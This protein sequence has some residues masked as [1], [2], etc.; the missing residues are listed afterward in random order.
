M[1]LIEVS[2]VRVMPS[3]D[4]RSPAWALDRPVTG[5]LFEG[6]LLEVSGWIVHPDVRSVEICQGDERLARTRVDAPRADVARLFPAIPAAGLSGFS[7][8]VPLAAWHDTTFVVSAV[9]RDA[10]PI[11]IA[12]IV[13]GRRWREACDESA[14]PL[15]S[16]VVTHYNGPGEL[17]ATIESVVA[18]TH[19]HSEILLV[20]QVALQEDDPL[21]RRY[22]HIRIVAADAPGQAAAR[23][24]GIRHSIGDFLMF[25]DRGDRLAPDALAIACAAFRDHPESA[26]VLG[27]RAGG[28]GIHS[29]TSPVPCDAAAR[30]AVFRRS[31]FGEV[32]VFSARTGAPESEMLARLARTFPLH[33][34][35]AVVAG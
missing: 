21:R 34:S 6:A 5:E 12:E 22:P 4:P 9:T 23:N 7:V 33:C 29:P 20:G 16:V 25:L 15:V 13:A 2:R 11:P 26:A 14:V 32:G 30:I 3:V 17:E 31:V 10:L 35:H 24:T 28:G 8:A 19:P 27:H 1:P 18:Q